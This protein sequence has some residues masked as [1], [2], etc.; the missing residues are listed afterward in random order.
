MKTPDSQ[1]AGPSHPWQNLNSLQKTEGDP[2][3]PDPAAEGDIQMEYSSDYLC[4][5]S[6]GAVTKITCK[7]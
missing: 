3:A 1:L 7:N 5:Q 6:M 2:H 4:S